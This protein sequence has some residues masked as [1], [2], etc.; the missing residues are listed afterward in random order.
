[1]AGMLV[2]AKERERE[3]ERERKREWGRYVQSRLA[4]KTRGY[5]SLEDR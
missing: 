5:T 1:M 2:E 3:R 4:V